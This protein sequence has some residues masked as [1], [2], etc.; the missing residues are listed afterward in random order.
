VLDTWRVNGLAGTG[1]HDVEVDDLF[2]P[3]A[4]T[5]ELLGTAAKRHEPLAAIPLPA[6]LG[7]SLMSVG[8]G[9]LRRAIEEFEALAASKTPFA[10]TR[11]LRERPSVQIDVARAAG[12]LDGA[13]AHVAAVCAEV[14][15][16]VRGGA[17]PATADLA[18][19]RLSY[20]TAMEQ[21][22]RGAELVRNAAGMNAVASGSALERCW[23]DLHAASQHFALSTAHYERIGRI[24]LG[25][26]PGPG[27]I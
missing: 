18:R 12:L 2:V 16:R 3:A 27:P 25:L 22:R 8:A 26:V 7:A 11:P 13:R 4:R 10:T 23:R 9:I 21:L 6:R 24:R 5:Y 1:S 17:K 19:L 14:F 20:V 15:G